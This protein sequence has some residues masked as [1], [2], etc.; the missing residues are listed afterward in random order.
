[1]D[2]FKLSSS[3]EASK[4]G[5]MESYQDIYGI[6]SRAI[7]SVGNSKHS[8]FGLKS[9]EHVVSVS[10]KWDCSVVSKWKTNGDEEVSG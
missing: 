8:A 5:F 10:K 6:I 4:V 7:M 9:R 2:Y 1:M 3:T